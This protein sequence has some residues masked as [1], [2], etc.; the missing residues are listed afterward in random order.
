MK[1]SVYRKAGK[2]IS[3]LSLREKALLI[4]ASVLLALVLLAGVGVD[5]LIR[6]SFANLENDWV[7]E[8][9]GR[10][11]QLIALESENLKRVTYDYSVWS[12][13]Y[14][15][16]SSPDTAYLRSNFSADVF[17]N[18][19]ITGAFIYRPDGT[20]VS[21]YILSSMKQDLEIA[22]SGWDNL[23]GDLTKRVFTGENKS[24]TGFIKHRDDVYF[25]SCHKIY[26]DSGAG[27][28]AGC[29]IHLRSFDQM[30]LDR[31]SAVA[32]LKIRIGELAVKENK[33][34]TASDSGGVFLYKKNGNDII[35]LV[36]PFNDIDENEIIAVET[37]LERKINQEGRIARFIFYILLAFIVLVSGLLN[38]FLLK[39]LVIFRLERMLRRVKEVGET[40]DLSKRLDL[41]DNDELDELAAGIN[42]ML[43]SLRDERNRCT[44]AESEKELMQEYML[45][46]KKMEAMGTMAGGIA[47]DFNNMLVIILGSAELLRVDLPA[48]HPVLEHVESIESAGR[49]ASAL[50]RRM[51]TISKGYSASKMYFSVTQT[52]NEMLTL[53]KA[54]LPG[55]ISISLSNTISDDLIYADIA[56]FQQIVINLVTNSSHAMAGRS[57]GS[58]EISVTDVVLPL[59]DYRVETAL[60]AEGRYLRIE[61]S[62]TGSGIPREIQ[63]RIFE[64]FF[65]TKPVGSGTGLG[66]A[67]VHGFV[68]N[69]GGS[70]GVESEPGNGTKFIIHLPAVEE[71]RRA[72]IHIG[73]ERSDILVVDDDTL[74]RK[75]LIAGLKRSGYVVHEAA[76]GQSALKLLEESGNDIKLVITDEMMPGM[77]GHELSGKMKLKYPEMPIILISGYLSGI[78]DS[79]FELQNFVKILM[80]PVSIAELDV[81]IREVLRESPETL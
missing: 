25:V 21:G 38:Q 43:D 33:D 35:H 10:V 15:F 42:R 70:I 48:D 13:T 3:S 11:Q 45:Q 36:I 23:L 77:S 34:F 53:V 67:V 59:A 2:H 81:V 80:K 30:L 32:G 40:L 69:N 61:F 79:V 71:K 75:T 9:A 52:I 41:R 1:F 16:I 22:D 78:D 74:V 37:F 18:L 64:P 39:K 72:V 12:D 58:L 20:R 28:P 24:L 68:V 56:Q 57:K 50:V 6:R 63:N 62:D 46:A 27:Y 55:Y 26:Q 5:F 31:V 47:H 51:M 54:N 66:L 44:E 73:N 8:S 19:Q 60:L 65:S 14:N 17:K 29:F 49:N 76:S 7:R 4:T